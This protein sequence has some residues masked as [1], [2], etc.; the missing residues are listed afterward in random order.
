[1]HYF[2]LKPLEAWLSAFFSRRFRAYPYI[3]ALF[4]TLVIR[5]QLEKIHS[6]NKCCIFLPWLLHSWYV[7]A[8]MNW[9][10]LLSVAHV[11]RKMPAAP[12]K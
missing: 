12:T 6:F 2:R 10:N 9:V 1:M 5:P 7:S 8:H 11:R 3:T 4:L